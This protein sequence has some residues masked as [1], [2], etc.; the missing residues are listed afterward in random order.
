MLRLLIAAGVVLYII[1]QAET[2]TANTPV[3]QAPGTLPLATANPTT[4]SPPG[5]MA[6]LAPSNPVGITTVPVSS[7]FSTTSLMASMSA[8]PGVGMSATV[9][10]TTP[11][12]GTNQ[13][14]L[15]GSIVNGAIAAWVVA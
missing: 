15:A 12:Q 13:P 14:Q 5:Q 11:A 6:Q 4:I 1:Y 10:P 3:P 2:Q 9:P 7:A 8:V